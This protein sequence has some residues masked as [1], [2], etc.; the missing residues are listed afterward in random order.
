MGGTFGHLPFRVTSR[1]RVNVQA[2]GMT[3]AGSMGPVA[4]FLRRNGV[5]S[6]PLFRRHGLSTRL[7]DEPERL[8][9]LRDQ[10]ALV[11]TAARTVGDDVFGA[12]L[13]T[14]VGF[15]GLGE[16]GRQVQ[17]LPTLGDALVASNA[18]MAKGLQS[19]T[20]MCLKRSAGL[21]RWTYAVT[22]RVEAGRGQNEL[23]ALG[24]QLDLLRRFC[25]PR[26][27]PTRIE[28]PDARRP[29]RAA[30]AEVFGCE[31]AVGR[32]AAVVFPERLLSRANP[33]P[34]RLADPHDRLPNADDLITCV[35]HLLE[36]AS[37]ERRPTLTELAHRLRLGPRTLQRRLAEQ[38]ESFDSLLR[39][40][41]QRRAGRLLAAGH[42][43]TDVAVE[44][45]YSDTAHFS[46]AYRTW[47]GRP[48]SADR[49]PK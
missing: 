34:R 45:G 31:V 22:E 39:K 20:E 30:A 49:A 16:F 24:Y 3:R 5:R 37:L 10:L 9:L 1:E 7:I 8:I 42:S 35:E 12:R 18:G 48:P 46:R 11:E 15:D 38:G 36:A 4:E 26:W 29:V 14:E 44:L 19:A 43:V 2:Y 6:D 27:L 28:L 13:S 32:V 23:L 21:A 33:A 40:A 47:T 41:F 17:R 25:G